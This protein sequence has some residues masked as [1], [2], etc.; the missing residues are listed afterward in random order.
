MKKKSNFLVYVVVIL[1][2]LL[3]ALFLG[4]RLTGKV[5]DGGFGEGV[6]RLESVK[7]DVT[8]TTDVRI[9]LDYDGSY[10]AVQEVF[11]NENCSV[12]GYYLYPESVE[13]N[14]EGPEIFGFNFIN[15][16]WLIVNRGGDLKGLE[17]RY[18]TDYDCDVV[19]GKY[20]DLN[21]SEEVVEYSF[22]VFSTWCG[23]AD[24][25]RS[26]EVDGDDL[27]ILTPHMDDVG[28]SDALE[29]NW[30]NWTDLNRD[31][32][33]SGADLTIM[34]NKMD[35]IDCADLCSRADHN[36]DG[37]VDGTDLSKLSSHFG[38]VNCSKVNNW[39]DWTDNNRD[40]HVDGTD[41]SR[42]GS[43]FGDT[44]CQA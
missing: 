22:G 41:L 12:S 35:D 40:D 19:E 17:L 43:A 37:K 38:E 10:L 4:F 8:N 20:F 6:G 24:I 5:I 31:G 3:A 7:N 33:V 28:C 21:E 23:R 36:F 32:N 29:N 9:V 26:G 13:F 39:C 27:N 18:S 11:S 2:V 34:N 16:T 44:G 15:N 42:V 30:C 14:P 25:D 1:I